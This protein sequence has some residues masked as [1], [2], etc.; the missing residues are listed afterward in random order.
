MLNH[1]FC[2]RRLTYLESSLVPVTH[3]RATSVHLEFS[4]VF[5]RETLLQLVK[6]LVTQNLF[7]RDYDIIYMN[8]DHQ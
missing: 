7:S 6:E 4:M 8:S 3:E 2:E 5:H 1:V